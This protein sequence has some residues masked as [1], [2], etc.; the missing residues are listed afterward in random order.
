MR[1][2]ADQSV[3]SEL[4]ELEVAKIAASRMECL[5]L[6]VDKVIDSFQ[7]E[8]FCLAGFMYSQQIT[9]KGITAKGKK[10]SEK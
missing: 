3:C 9:E 1:L 2:N 7:D 10:T 5:R 8:L 6:L 4:L